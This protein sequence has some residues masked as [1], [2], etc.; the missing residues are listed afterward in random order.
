MKLPFIIA[1]ISA[2]HNGSLSHAKKLIKLAKQQGASAVKI[3]TYTADTMTLNSK[4]K[5]YMIKSGLWKGKT[6][7]DLYEKAKTPLKWHKE[8]FDYAKKIKL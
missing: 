2:N 7:W 8:L 4:E 6:L 3:Q 5:I 1:E